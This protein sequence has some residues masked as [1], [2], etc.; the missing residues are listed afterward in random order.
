MSNVAILLAAGSSSR[1]Q[2]VISD[3]AL[4]LINEKPLIAYSLEA[5]IQSSIVQSYV[6]V[7]RDELQQERLQDILS[8]YIINMTFIQGGPSRQDSVRN[9]LHSLQQ[10][11]NNVYIHDCARPLITPLALK[12]LSQVLEESPATCL[13]H[14]VTDTIKEVLSGHKLRELNRDN[15]WAIETPQAFKF[16]LIYRCH[17]HLFAEGISV[18]DDTSAVSYLGHPVCIVKNDNPNPKLT[19]PGDLA[20]TEY[21]VRNNQSYVS[22]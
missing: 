1:M 13:A 17:E 6:V 14:P 2:N 16:E 22:I 10:T 4:T 3:K 18:T 20:L 21:L 8:H 7:Y 5:F 15:L 19:Y 9:A 11:T 12:K